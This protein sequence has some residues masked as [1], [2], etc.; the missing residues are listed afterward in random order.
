MYML[1]RCYYLI[2]FYQLIFSWIISDYTRVNIQ[3]NYKLVII[4][5]RTVY[6]ILQYSTSVTSKDVQHLE[7]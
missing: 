4:I 7:Y 3:L 6:I 1:T 5:P 2:L